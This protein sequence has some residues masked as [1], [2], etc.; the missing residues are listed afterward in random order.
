MQLDFLCEPAGAAPAALTL[1]IDS[2]VIAGWTGRDVDAMEAHIRELEEIG[3]PRPAQTPTY[4]RV[5]AS[6]LT[7][8]GE[9]E[10]A[11]TG[12]SGEVEFVLFMSGGQHYVGLGSDHTDR[13]LEK[14]GVTWSK[15]ACPKPIGANLWRLADLTDHWDRLVLRSWATMDGVRSLYQEGP[16]TTMRDPM[17]LLSGF[18][19]GGAKPAGL[20]MFCG[21]LAVQ[22]GL[23][24]ADL[25]EIELEDPVLDRRLHHAYR[26]RPLPIAG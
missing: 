4:Y 15:Q 22:G 16:V 8:A 12:S 3:V 11:G 10:V 20:A 17:E 19:K 6:L 23:R 5:G 2:L 14:T 7:Q 9:I 26:V 24:P 25:F 1:E 21:T 18:L 13:E